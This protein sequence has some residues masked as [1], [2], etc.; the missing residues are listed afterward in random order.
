MN[1][2]S[3]EAALALTVKEFEAHVISSDHLNATLKAIMI[4]RTY[5]SR[6]DLGRSEDYFAKAVVHARKAKLAVE[7]V[8]AL[9]EQAVTVAARGNETQ[10]RLLLNQ[11]I[12]RGSQTGIDV[13]VWTQKLKDLR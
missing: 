10:A 2:S 4:G 3:P 12:S 9:G 1:S 8:N 5:R 13:S 11:A 6:G 7:E